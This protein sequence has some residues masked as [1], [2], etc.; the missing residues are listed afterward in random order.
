VEF[1]ANSCKKDKKSE[2]RKEERGE[3]QRGKQDKNQ[4]SSTFVKTMADREVG[5]QGRQTVRL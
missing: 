4:M 1:L 5:G 3:A 2:N